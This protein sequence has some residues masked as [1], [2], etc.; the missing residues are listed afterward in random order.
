MTKETCTI[1]G[2]IGE[3]LAAAMSYAKWHSFW[4][5]LGHFLLGWIYVIYYLIAYGSPF[6][7]L[8]H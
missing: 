7:H 1:I 5:A 8:V 4:Y 3:I 2:T 6:T